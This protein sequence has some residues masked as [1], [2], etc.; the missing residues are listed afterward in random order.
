[1]TKF[2]LSNM[3][4]KPFET[5]QKMS[6]GDKAKV[7]CA[8]IAGL[9]FATVAAYVGGEIATTNG[10]TPSSLVNVARWGMAEAGVVIQGIAATLGL[11]LPGIYAMCK[12]DAGSH[13]GPPSALTMG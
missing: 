7:I 9:C 3:G 12:R 1:M 8:S 2:S 6:K 13:Q 4:E 10:V 11:A 5:S